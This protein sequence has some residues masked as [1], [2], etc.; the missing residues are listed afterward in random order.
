MVLVLKQKLMRVKMMEKNDKI[1][2]EF[3][4]DEGKLITRLSFKIILKEPKEDTD[5]GD[6]N[7]S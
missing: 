2:K 1:V 7:G 6:K 3:Y 5:S 4:D